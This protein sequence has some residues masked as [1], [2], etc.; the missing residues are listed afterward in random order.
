MNSLQSSNTNWIPVQLM[1]T[2]YHK[3]HLNPI[4]V[5]SWVNVAL[6]FRC[7]KLEQ[8]Q[9]FLNF[10]KYKFSNHLFKKSSDVVSSVFP[11]TQ[12]CWTLTVAAYVGLGPS[13]DQKGGFI[14]PL[15]YGNFMWFIQLK[16]HYSKEYTVQ[17][18]GYFGSRLVQGCI[19][20]GL[21][22]RLFYIYFLHGV[23]SLSEFCGV[24]YWVILR[25]NH[26]RVIYCRS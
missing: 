8:M 21:T 16:I 3:G 10:L 1:K 9:L 22:N 24:H 13:R 26:N 4:Q 12:E 7:Q 15:F 19:W 18:N 5:F 6:Y 20:A 17:G 25:C 11:K 2:W 14:Y 23:Q